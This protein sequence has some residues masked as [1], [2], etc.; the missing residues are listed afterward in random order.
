MDK[1]FIQIFVLLLFT[2]FTLAI[3]GDDTT[4]I[5]EACDGTDLNG[6]TCTNISAGFT[7]GSIS[8]LK[9]CS[10]YNTSSCTR[11]NVHYAEQLTFERFSIRWLTDG[12]DTYTGPDSGDLAA[13]D[14][15]IE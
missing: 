3:C 2:S 4:D 10:A 12:R 6:F 1:I 13:D 7:G 5:G 9:D 14:Q 8:C 11:G 15:D